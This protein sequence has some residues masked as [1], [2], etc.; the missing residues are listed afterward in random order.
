MEGEGGRNAP[1]STVVSDP[2]GSRRNTVT[3]YG[4]ESTQSHGGSHVGLYPISR[5][6]S[7]LNCTLPAELA[8][9]VHMGTG[10]NLPAAPMEYVAPAVRWLHCTLSLP[11]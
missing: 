9:T 3:S 6:T 10:Q 5:S 1:V 2:S 7:A 4:S 11:V 8:V